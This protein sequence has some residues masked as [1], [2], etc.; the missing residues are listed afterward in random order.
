[1]TVWVKFKIEELSG[2]KARIWV[3]WSTSELPL[4]SP[5]VDHCLC[6]VQRNDCDATQYTS[7]RVLTTS[8][9]SQP[10]V[11][12]HLVH[13]VQIVVPRTF[14]EYTSRRVLTT[15]WLEGEKLSGS[16]AD[17]VDE[18]IDIGVPSTS[19]TCCRPSCLCCADCGATHLHREHL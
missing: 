19:T 2:S 16:K 11:V 13:V 12:D 5:V 6:A 7:R 1:M 10:I 15:S 3:N 9:L 14:T 18:L 4:S 17:D 8:W